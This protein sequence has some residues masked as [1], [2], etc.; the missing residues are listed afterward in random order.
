MST[1]QAGSLF[2]RSLVL[3]GSQQDQRRRDQRGNGCTRGRWRIRVWVRVADSLRDSLWSS[4]PRLG[5]LSSAQGVG[6][7][8]Q[9]QEEEVVTLFEP[10]GEFD[11]IRDEVPDSIHHRLAVLPNQDRSSSVS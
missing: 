10:T 5:S 1:P 3:R 11:R 2:S 4:H 6:G 9:S 8:I 7:F